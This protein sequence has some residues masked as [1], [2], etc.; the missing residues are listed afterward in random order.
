M[1]S[2]AI[3]YPLYATLNTDEKVDGSCVYCDTYTKEDTTVKLH[4]IGHG[5]L[6]SQP[7]NYCLH[8]GCGYTVPEHSGQRSGCS[9]WW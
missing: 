9:K 3:S 5:H 6:A 1:Y 7:L 8:A 2:C 4:R